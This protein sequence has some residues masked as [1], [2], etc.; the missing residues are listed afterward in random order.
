M[1]AGGRDA[2]RVAAELVDQLRGDGLALA[3]VFADWRLDAA[4][5]AR[6][7]QRALGPVPVV[8]CTSIGVI[9]TGASTDDEVPAA[10]ALGLY[11]DWVR[12][13]VGVAAELSH[14]AIARSRDAVGRAA[15][16]LGTTPEAL[17]P[18]R[19][20]AF[21]VVDGS[22]GQEEA[23]CIGSAIAAPQIRMVGGCAAAEFNSTARAFWNLVWDTFM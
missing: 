23:F 20:V 3:V 1:T 13:G 18:M 14:S 5:L 4:V 8:G 19:H 17:D 6:E 11:G 16:A 15:R 21:T 10:V 9:G 12:V 22:S 2:A 7:L